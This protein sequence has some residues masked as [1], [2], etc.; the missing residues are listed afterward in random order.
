MP[1]GRSKSVRLGIGFGGLRNHGF[2]ASTDL[3]RASIKAEEFGFES[4]WVPENYYTNDSL[5]ILATIGA[6]TRRIRLATS[7]VN[8]YT[9]HTTILALTACTLDELT[10]GRVILGLGVSPKILINGQMG[11][12]TYKPLTVIRESVEVLRR[13][14]R[15]ERLD[16]FQGTF[17]NVKN[18]KLENARLNNTGIPVYVAAIGP[19]MLQ[20]AGEIG[21]GVVLTEICSPEYVDYARTQ[22]RIGA[23]RAGRKIE[24]ID[25]VCRILTSIEP[26][27]LKVHKTVIGSFFFKM[28]K[29]DLVLIGHPIDPD[30]MSLVKEAGLRGDYAAAS[31][32]VPDDVV[33]GCSI[34]GTPEEAMRRLDEYRRAGV[35]LPVLCPPQNQ[36][37]RVIQVFGQ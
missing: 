1:S 15:G 30:S 35:T 5:V 21:D 3:V 19:K 2:A 27:N 23:E 13:L 37:D 28:E 16:N 11:I 18:V 26:S 20:L 6:L 22:I 10:S 24:D 14:T 33:T 31:E 4:T 12:E 7:I 34:L 17:L 29:A 32:H 9:H 36:V 8:P 25:I